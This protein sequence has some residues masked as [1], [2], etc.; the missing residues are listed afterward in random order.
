MPKVNKKVIKPGVDITAEKADRLKTKLL[1]FI[2]K[3][4]DQLII[5]CEKVNEVDPVGL[6][7]IVAAYNTLRYKNAKLGMINIRNDIY[8]QL[9]GLGIDQNIELRG[10]E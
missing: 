10:L 4:P 9:K 1:K 3:S 8:S 6:S 5:D 2:D 7:V